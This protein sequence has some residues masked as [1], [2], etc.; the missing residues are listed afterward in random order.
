MRQSGKD[1]AFAALIKA[2]CTA[3]GRSLRTGQRHAAEGHDDWTRFTQGQACAAVTTKDAL[4]PSVLQVTALAALSPLHPPDLPKPSECSET[5]SEP[6]RVMRDAW[7]M[8]RTHFDLWQR[9]LHG[10]IIPATD[11]TPEQII[12]ADQAMACVHAKLCIDLRE[13]YNEALRDFTQWEIEQR[14]LIPVN[15]Y[16]ATHAEVGIPLANLMSTMPT[17]LAASVNPEN[18]THAFR[19]LTDWLQKRAQPAIDAF[20]RK[21]EENMPGT[22]R[23]AA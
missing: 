1:R 19:V 6:E 22:S 9:N 11:K 16:A 8:W 10:A 7:S 2:Y 14:R 5:M 18:S 23:L 20:L 17:E 15:E 12:P 13:Q 3:T 21:L 4:A